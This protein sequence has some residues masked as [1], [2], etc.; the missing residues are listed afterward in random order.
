MV[1]LPNT[2]SET[3]LLS[4]IKKLTDSS[5]IDRFIVRLPFPKQIDMRKVVIAVDTNKNISGFHPINFRKMALDLS[6]FIPAIFFGILELMDG[7]RI[8]SQEK[9]PVV[10]RSFS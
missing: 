9:H 7:H 10:N 4:E 8:V 5:D 6:T 3:E 1:R 2:K